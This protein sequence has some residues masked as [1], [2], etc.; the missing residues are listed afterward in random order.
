MLMPFL[1]G[2]IVDTAPAI[3]K[4][5]I[6]GKPRV[7]D[8]PAQGKLRLA[9]SDPITLDPSLV[10]DIGSYQYI[11]MI[12]SGL[13][14]IDD[15]MKIIPDLATKWD[16][17]PD[18]RTYT[19]HLRNNA[20][21]QNGTALTADAFKFAIERATDPRTKSQVAQ[22]YLGDIVGA[23]D[24]IMGKA[25][26]VSG[27]R[28]KDPYTLELEIDAPK[29]FFLAKL[30]YP[31]AFALDKSTVEA[32]RNWTRQPNGSGPFKLKSWQADQSMVFQ[33][34]E[35]YYGQKPGVA[36]VEFYLGGGSPVTMYERNDLDVAD[37]NIGDIERA[38]DPR[39]A[40]NKDLVTVPEL[41]IT[42]IGLNTTLKPF[43]DVKVRQ[44]FAYATDKDKLTNILLKKTRVKAKGVLPPG[45]PGYNETFT[46]IGLD[47]QKAKE[48]LAQSSYG[49]A[50]NLPDITMTVSAGNDTV[51]R[52][53]AEMYRR[54]LGVEISVQQVDDV[55][56]Q[57]VEERKYQM[58]ITGWIAD[59]PDQQDFLDVFFYSRSTGNYTV[60]EDRG[61]DQ[62]LEAARI[63]ADEKKRDSI[64]QDIE[65]QVVGMAPMIPLY[66][67][68]KYALVKPYVKGLVLSPLGI[69]VLR[70]VTIEK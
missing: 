44:A 9:G 3:D 19:F 28:V 23:I 15:Q 16:V 34:N 2:C 57:E 36:E 40:L 6:E 39:S 62:M 11:G 31:T 49:S 43:D 42:Y 8:R 38:L 22:L 24:K 14:T 20:K 63:E 32:D 48:L 41:S 46:G 29:A 10:G 54:N 37:V 65:S 17:S 35:L 60:F 5:E 61:I 68:V 56:N 1:T 45:M 21:F 53:L 51:A 27:V 18:G 67:D 12:Y 25:R 64:Y 4:T 52:S 59:Y 55:F 13:V 7:I 50:A 33:R 30:T 69:I 70:D 47:P 26:E 66:H 58:F